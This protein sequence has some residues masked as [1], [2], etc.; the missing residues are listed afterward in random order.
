MAGK[1]KVS[2]VPAPTSG[3]NLKDNLV[4]LQPTEATVMKNVYPDDGYCRLIGPYRPA[5]YSADDPVS[6]WGINPRMTI[7]IP[8]TDTTFLIVTWR[9]SITYSGLYN[10]ATGVLTDADPDTVLTSLSNGVITDNNWVRFGSS[11]FIALYESGTPASTIS[12]YNGTKFIASGFTFV[13]TPVLYY[14]C[15][16]RSRLYAAGG[17]EIQYGAVD[18]LTGA[19]AKFD[20]DRIFTTKGDITG[21]GTTTKQTANV[22]QQL[23][24]IVNAAGEVLIYQGDYPGSTTWGIVDRFFV[25]LTGYG[26]V[27]YIGSDLHILSSQGITP[28]AALLSNQKV[29]EEYVTISDKINNSVKDVWRETLTLSTTGTRP[30]MSA[31][32]LSQRQAVLLSLWGLNDSTTDWANL[33][34][35]IMNNNTKSW[36][37]IDFTETT[38]AFVSWSYPVRWI[39]CGGKLFCWGPDQ[40]YEVDITYSD[41]AGYSSPPDLIY[42]PPEIK[43]AHT[44]LDDPVNMKSIKQVRALLSAK[45]LRPAAV[46]PTNLDFNWEVGTIRDFFSRESMSSVRFTAG[47]E[48]EIHNGNW[49][50]LADMGRAISFYYGDILP[51]AGGEWNQPLLLKLFALEVQFETGSVM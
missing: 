31:T 6:L 5:Y 23:F 32:H 45:Q 11:D 44:Y 40:M 14:L 51:Q 49:A 24:V 8:Q 15:S 19:M 34:F 35:L 41:P 27:T 22:D 33:R 30:Y 50:G 28:V 37:E 39:E 47:H 21:I 3:L 42:Y 16:Y 43:T 12:Y 4:Q 9:L 17:R 10:T 48:E 20:L 29:N 38:E 26:C 7:F 2:V 13:D 36:G 1:V 46:S 18:A 25:G